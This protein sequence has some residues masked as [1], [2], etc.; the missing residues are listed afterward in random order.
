VDDL[1]I[2]HVEL[3]RSNRHTENSNVSQPFVEHLTKKSSAIGTNE[4][5]CPSSLIMVNKNHVKYQDTPKHNNPEM[6]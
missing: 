2:M 1:Y 6:F 3:S 4:M 5:A